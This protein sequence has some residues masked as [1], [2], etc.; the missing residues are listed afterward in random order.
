[1]RESIL[2]P[3]AKV[4]QGYAGVMPTFKGVLSDQQ[5]TAIIEFIK[6]VQL[7]R[8][9]PGEVIDSDRDNYFNSS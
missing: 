3:A 5:I 6:S 7:I 4:R 2:E 8:L 9:S 1:V